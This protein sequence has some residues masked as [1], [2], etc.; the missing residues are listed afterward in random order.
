MDNSIIPVI[1][2][3]ERIYDA[4]ST[5]LAFKAPRPI[6]TIQ[7]K[8]RQKQTLGWFWAEGW[9][10]DKKT[11]GEINICAEDLNTTPVETLVHEIVHY[12]NNCEKIKDCNSQQYHNKRFKERAESYGLNVTKDGRHGWAYTSLGDD[13]KK[14]LE[15]LKIDKEVF[16][17]YRKSHVSMT[18]PTKMKKY[19]CQ[20]TTV[21]CATD[22]QAT[23]KK[24]GKEFE[25]QE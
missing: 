5:K 9:S 23:C 14:T 25:E 3:L 18:A 1:K 20:C 4:L 2:E 12:A 11:I 16:T 13:L 24:C 6:I 8:G 10:R 15:G 17:L 22:L 19:R 21:R 7:T